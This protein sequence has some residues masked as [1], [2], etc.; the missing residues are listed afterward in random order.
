MAVKREDIAMR[1]I[2]GARPIYVKGYVAAWLIRQ[3]NTGEISGGNSFSCCQHVFQRRDKRA[4]R[5]FR[6][7][8][9]AHA[10]QGSHGIL[11]LAYRKGNR[12]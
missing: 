7:M 10:D 12:K 8:R 6:R 9:L 5:R 3:P 1:K 11:H 4:R 2:S